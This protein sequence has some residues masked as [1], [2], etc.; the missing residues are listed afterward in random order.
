MLR[1]ILN[2]IWLVLCGFWM[3]IA[4]AIAGIICFVLFFLVVTIPF[5]I[6]AFRIAGYVLWPFGRSIERARDAG[7]RLADRQHHLDHPVRLG[8]GP[9]SSDHRR[10]ALHH[11]H[12]H[13]ARPGQLQDHPH[14]AGA[15]RRRRA[16]RPALSGLSLTCPVAYRLLMCRISRS[17]VR[18]RPTVSDQDVQAAAIQFVQTVSGSRP[19]PADAEVFDRAVDMIASVTRDLL[20]GSRCPPPID[21]RPPTVPMVGA[22][23]MS[24]EF[25]EVDAVRVVQV[26][27]AVPARL[28]GR[29][30]RRSGWSPGRSR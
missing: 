9:R 21:S 15:A 11:H 18:T 17:C 20:A 10:P 13:P 6:A 29:T 26:A 12:R 22:C 19:M 3:A 25:G 8:A 30:A 24:S 1:F 5:G 2:I 23:V 27:G 7:R 16:V 28:C 4:Y 14:L